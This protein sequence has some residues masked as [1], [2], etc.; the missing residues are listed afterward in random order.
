[1]SEEAPVKKCPPGQHDGEQIGSW[2]C[3]SWDYDY[4]YR[5]RRCGYEYVIC[6]S[7]LR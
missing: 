6:E 7:E 2:P 3:D 1:M 4:K 5:C